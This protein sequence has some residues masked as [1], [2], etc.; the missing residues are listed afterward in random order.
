MY[1]QIYPYFDSV[2]SKFQCE[3][4]KGLNAQYCLLT[5]VEKWHKTL[6]EGGETGAVLTDLSKAFDCIDHNLLIAKLNAYRF[7]K[8][9]LAFI[10][11][12]LTKRKQ[13]TKVDSAFSSWEM[14]LSGV[15]QGSIL[16]PLLFNIYI[17]DLFFETPENIGFA[18]YA[19]DN[20]PYTYSSKIEDVLSNLQGASEILFSWFS[21]NHLVANAGKCHL[22]TSSNLPVDIRIKNTNISNGERV[23]LLGGNIEGRLNFDYHVNTLLKKA[24]K[25]HHA[26]ARVCNYMD[27]K[28]R[29]ALMKAFI[30]SQFSYCPLVWMFHSRTL[31]NR[32][33]KIHERALRLVYKNETFLLMTY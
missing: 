21:A 20:T 5:M 10:H 8:R 4:R 11:S 29:H 28:T 22:L 3:F 14:L 12:Y 13:R 6:D 26:L 7:E 2:F 32:I 1:T 16:G 9:S 18:G 27:T 23:K 15:L 31:N 19:D 33:N 25:K 24:N 30:T 17:C